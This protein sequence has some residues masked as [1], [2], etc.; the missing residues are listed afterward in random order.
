MFLGT[1]NEKQCLK[2]CLKHPNN[3]CAIRQ[4]EKDGGGS[5]LVF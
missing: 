5:N 3:L 2:K 4:R 1:H